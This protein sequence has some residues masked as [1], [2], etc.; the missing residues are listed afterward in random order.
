MEGE[1]LDPG[2][3]LKISVEFLSYKSVKVLE[4]IVGIIPK[5]MIDSQGKTLLH[6]AAQQGQTSKI[7][8]LVDADLVDPALKDN[9]GQTALEIAM[10]KKHLK[11]IKYFIGLGLSCTVKIQ[12]ALNPAVD[13]DMEGRIINCIYADNIEELRNN[14]LYVTNING[15]FSSYKFYEWTLLGVAAFY[16]SPKCLEYLLRLGCSPDVCEGD[17][18]SFIDN[19]L[20]AVLEVAPPETEEEYIAYN[21]GI[22]TLLVIINNIKGLE[23]YKVRLWNI[24][25]TSKLVGKHSSRAENQYEEAVVT[26]NLVFGLTLGRF[27]DTIC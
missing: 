16:L 24:F 20:N 21:S 6:H 2:E 18:L 25:N 15:F 8:F 1:D 7:A 23:K 9:L 14:M 10:K 22:E 17:G 4:E 13:L 12:L 19:A 5:N 3:P 27:L 11:I 26:K